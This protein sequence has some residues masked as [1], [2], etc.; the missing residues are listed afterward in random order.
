MPEIQHTVC[1]SA[2]KTGSIN[3]V[4]SPRE[5]RLD[6][7]RYVFR[8]VFNVCILND[9]YI[10]SCR[11]DASSYSCAF[12]FVLFMKDDLLRITAGSSAEDFACAIGRMVIDDD[13]LL[14]LVRT[15]IYTR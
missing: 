8:I 6:D 12:S 14:W 9:N 10:S 5:D 4:G 13:Y 7:P 1:F 15:S 2:S 11:R 3:D